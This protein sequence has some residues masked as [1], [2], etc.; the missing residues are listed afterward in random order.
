[1]VPP[2]DTPIVIDFVFDSCPACKATY[3]KLVDCFDLTNILYTT[4][5]LSAYVDQVIKIENCDNC[6]QVTETRVFTEVSNV[7]VVSDFETCEDCYVD[8]PCICS[9]ITNLTATTKTISYIDCENDEVDITLLVNET[10]SKLCAKRWILPDLP[11]G[12]F[13]YIETFGNCQ[14]GVCPQPT[15]TNNRTIRPGYNTPICTPAKYD[16]ITCRFADILYKIALEERYGITNC[17]PDEDDKWLIKKELIDLQALKDP[18]YNCKECEC[19]C[20]I[21]NTC[22]TCNCKN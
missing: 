21:G 14:Q 17:C 11:V 5:N 10:S 13:L 7:V 12:Q 8:A 4:S 19:G 18:N 15:F 9:K 1:M 20:N 3:Y 22:S 2:T 6:W 16:E